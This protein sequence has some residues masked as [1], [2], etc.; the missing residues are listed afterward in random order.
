LQI[1][2]INITQL[3]RLAEHDASLLAADGLHPSGAMYALWVDI[4]MQTQQKKI[5]AALKE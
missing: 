3:S 1:P 4:I 2:F 5:M